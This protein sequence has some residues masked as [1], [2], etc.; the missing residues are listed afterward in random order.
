M[1]IKDKAWDPERVHLWTTPVPTGDDTT[2]ADPHAAGAPHISDPGGDQH[3]AGNAWAQ[4][5][6]THSLPI[7]PRGVMIPP[8]SQERRTAGCAI[9]DAAPSNV[10]APNE[11][12]NRPSHP[13]RTADEHG[14]ASAQA[15]KRGHHVAMIEVPDE[16]DDT[17]Y[18]RWLAK[19]SPIVTLTRPV[20]TLP[21]PPDSPI[22]IG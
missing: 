14:S 22:Q 17:A 1:K 11:T 18:Q 6:S 12:K 8:G 15:V 9:A 3:A 10:G 21:M 20:V 16:D 19:G 2:D 4:P 13:D 5:V 7:Q